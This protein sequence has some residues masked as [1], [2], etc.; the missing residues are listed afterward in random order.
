M[1]SRN[2]RKKYM[3]QSEFVYNILDW[4]TARALCTRLVGFGLNGTVNSTILGT[5]TRFETNGF[6]HT[7]NRKN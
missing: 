3:A 7:Q 5:V 1:R 6:V 4:P 2:L